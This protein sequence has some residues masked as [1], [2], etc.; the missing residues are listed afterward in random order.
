VVQITRVLSRLIESLFDAPIVTEAVDLDRDVLSPLATEEAAGLPSA[1]EARLLEYRAGRHC[2]RCA[3]AR[4]GA[5]GLVV[6]RASDRSPVWPGGFVGSI[7]HTRR[8][9]RGVAAAVVARESEVR[10]VGLDMEIDE[11]L[12]TSLFRKILRDSERAA[13]QERPESAHGSLA[14]L[15]FS[16]KECVYKCQHPLSKTFLE[17]S[18]VEV[19]LPSGGDSGVLVA[20]LCRD[21]GP[22]SAGTAFTV[23]YVRGEGLVAT[24]TTL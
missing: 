9:G 24:G 23:R 11:P 21:A 16:A 13:L 19:V 10:S 4:L 15:V 7:S 5:E 14:K 3:L 22:L 1:A 17:F 12:E 18:D 20:R 8:G 6:T 2:A